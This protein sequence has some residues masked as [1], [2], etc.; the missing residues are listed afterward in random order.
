MRE[1]CFAFALANAIFVILLLFYFPIVWLNLLFTFSDLPTENIPFYGECGETAVTSTFCVLLDF[2]FSTGRY[3]FF[4]WLMMTDVFLI[5]VPIIPFATMLYLIFRKE[6]QNIFPMYTLPLSFIAA[7][8]LVKVLFLSLGYAFCQNIDPCRNFNSADENQNPNQPNY[9]YACATFFGIP[10][11]L[12]P[13]IYA[14]ITAA[15][16]HGMKDFQNEY[17]IQETKEKKE[18]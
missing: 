13:M 1:L 12:F 8:Q 15:F 11:T 17:S 14:Y 16:Y 10:F 7:F 6:W 18:Q 5:A 3:H 2:F 4:W 9:V